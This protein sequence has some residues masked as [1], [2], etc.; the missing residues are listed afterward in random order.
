MDIVDVCATLKYV[1]LR[2]EETVVSELL[3]VSKRLEAV[4]KLLDRMVTMTEGNPPTEPIR[5]LG[6]DADLARA[7]NAV[8]RLRGRLTTLAVRSASGH[9][10]LGPSVT[11]AAHDE[12]SKTFARL[13]EQGH[14][15]AS[16]AFQERAGVSRQALSKA[17]AER[18]LFYI[19]F[20]RRRGYPAFYTDLSLQRKQI[21][22][23]SKILGDLSGG[24]KWLFFTTPKGSLASPDTGVPRTPLQALRDGEYARVTL[25]ASGY[26]QR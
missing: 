1:V 7:L 11:R 23:V 8:E 5:R 15:L 20:G 19:D 6:S 21:G 26:A 24:S 13:L 22:E 18:R 10:V 3:R 16:G 4:E 2:G 12:V 9:S 25:A 17:V 14:L